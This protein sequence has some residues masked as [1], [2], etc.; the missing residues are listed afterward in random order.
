MSLSP[1][2]VLARLADNERTKAQEAL[3]SLGRQRQVLQQRRGEVEVAMQQLIVQRDATLKAGT[4]AS[5]LLMM[6]AAKREQQLYLLKIES[7]MNELYESEA[8]LIRDWVAAN[9]KHDSHDK[10]QKTLD[11]KALKANDVRSQ[12]QM[13]DIFAAKY[14]REGSAYE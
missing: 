6:E 13:D 8:A 2:Q 1:H 12:K 11:K 7:E 9:Q 4:E 10:M 5:M 3:A 14:V